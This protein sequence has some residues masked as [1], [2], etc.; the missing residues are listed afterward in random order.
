MPS[1]TW[2]RGSILAT[3]L[4]LALPALPGCSDDGGTGA[5]P[6]GGPSSGAAGSTNDKGAGPSGPG[7]GGTGSAGVDKNS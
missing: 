5:G 7:T 3:I 4:G 2:L 1:K 6:G